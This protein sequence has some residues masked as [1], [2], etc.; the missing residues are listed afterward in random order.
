[1]CSWGNGKYFAS[2]MD[3]LGITCDEIIELYN[4]KIKTAPTSFYGKM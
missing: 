4:E 1:M 2:I 3:G